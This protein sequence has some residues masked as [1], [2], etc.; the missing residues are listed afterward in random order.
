MDCEGA[1]YK[2]LMNQ[3]LSNIDYLAMEIHNQ[4]GKERILTLRNYLEERFEIVKKQ[5]GNRWRHLEI[6]Y[7]RKDI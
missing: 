2:F 5:H 4:L 1:E 6:L 3:D 7:K